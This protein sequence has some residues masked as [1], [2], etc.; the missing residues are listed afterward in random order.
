MGS[1]RVPKMASNGCGTSVPPKEDTIA[2]E[3]LV[4]YFLSFRRLERFSEPR[5]LI[6]DQGVHGVEH[7]RAECFGSIWMLVLTVQSEVRGCVTPPRTS[8]ETG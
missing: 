1:T 2:C 7:E 8:Q 4:H 6:F 3:S 5:Q